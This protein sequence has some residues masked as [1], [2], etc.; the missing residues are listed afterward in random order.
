[1]LKVRTRAIE[2]LSWDSDFFGH[3]IARLT[4]PVL[5][6]QV[7]RRAFVECKKL[8]IECLYARPDGNDQKSIE[9]AERNGFALVG[10]RVTYER[11]AARDRAKGEGITVR[12]ASVADRE[13]LAKLTDDLSKESRFFRD[14]RFGAVAAKRLYRAWVDK[15]LLNTSP[16]ARV[17][18]AMHDGACVGF[19]AA[20]AKGGVVHIEL[21]IVAR[22][23]R[24]KGV[25]K[26]LVDT[27]MRSY[28]KEGFTKFRVV[29]QGSNIPA[30][31]LYQACGFRVTGMSLDY[32]KW[33]V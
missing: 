14:E 26:A 9:V 27:C 16:S 23:A 33:F 12:T 22:S 1:M 20:N 29:T 10:T 32:H 2:Y 4:A 13:L 30:Q 17:Q 3:A 31:R 24:G 7:V 25:G 6:K 8:G 21:V 11:E 5:N 15:L 28:G 18:V 19:I